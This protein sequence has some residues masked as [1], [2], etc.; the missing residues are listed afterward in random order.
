M[1]PCPS[2][3]G[4]YYNVTKADSSSNKYPVDNLMWKCTQYPL[5]SVVLQSKY[6]YSQAEHGTVLLVVLCRRWQR[7]KTVYAGRHHHPELD[8]RAGLQESELY[9]QGSPS[10]GKVSE[11]TPAIGLSEFS[12]GRESEPEALE[13][14]VQSV[15]SQVSKYEMKLAL[16]GQREVSMEDL[17]G[18]FYLLLLGAVFGFLLVGAEKTFHKLKMVMKKYDKP[19][20]S[21]VWSYEKHQLAL[22]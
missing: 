8:G 14:A 22:F 4:S 9:L 19:V 10:P 1:L 13:G 6:R 11:W 3:T 17:Q 5:S 15:I 21:K 16:P 18:P 2:E 12:D 7:C 20:R